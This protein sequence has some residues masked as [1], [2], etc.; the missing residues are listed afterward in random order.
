MICSK[1][2]LL[3]TSYRIK[4]FETFKIINLIKNHPICK[5]YLIVLM[6]RLR[7]LMNSSV[8]REKYTAT[9]IHL[10]FV[11]C[12][13]LSSMSS[14]RYEQLHDNLAIGKGDQ[15]GKI[16]PST[17]EI[18]IFRTYSSGKGAPLSLKIKLNAGCV[19]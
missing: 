9:C 12:Y 10:V 4:T 16:V 18:I 7:N 8:G 3:K 2:F 14:Q 13:R 19:I 6:Y 5:E 1:T 11:L 17:S 15:R